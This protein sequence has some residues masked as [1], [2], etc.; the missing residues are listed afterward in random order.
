[1]FITSGGEFTKR[2]SIRVFTGNNI[3]IYVCPLFG[4]LFCLNRT[5]KSITNRPY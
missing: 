4:T 1:M 3:Y 5:Q 2:I